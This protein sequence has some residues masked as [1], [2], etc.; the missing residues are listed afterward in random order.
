MSMLAPPPVIED[1]VC[2]SIRGFP[3][4]ISY[5]PN[6][7]IGKF[8]YYRGIFEEQVIAKISKNIRPGMTVLDVGA[9]IGLHTL[10]FAHLVGI[11]G[12]VVSVE[13]QESVRKRLLKNIELNSF[14]NI[15]VLPCA[16]G[17]R[18]ESGYIYQLYENNDGAACLKPCSPT[19]T[20]SKETITIRT[21]D[22]VRK[23]CQVEYFD[24]LKIDV[25][26]AELDV[27]SG[28]EGLFDGPRRPRAVFVE[29][30]DSHLRR[31][32]HTSQ[33]LV[34]WLQSRGYEVRALRTGRWSHLNSSEGLDCDLFATPRTRSRG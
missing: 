30:I 6:T 15:C 25:E 26:G 31:F 24:L 7:Y 12:R 20:A 5:D 17:A 21:L 22:Y 11:R 28:I 29:C 33:E 2:T 3:L 14:N 8:L 34:S 1:S 23:T 19:T 16:L 18:E 9:N 4:R 10:I 13:P 27:L 32:G